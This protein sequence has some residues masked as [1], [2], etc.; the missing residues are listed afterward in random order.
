M[1]S[2]TAGGGEAAAAALGGRRRRGLW[3]GG[4]AQFGS[5]VVLCSSPRPTLLIKDDVQDFGR[6]R[7]EGFS[8]CFKFEGALIEFC[9]NVKV[10]VG[11]VMST[12]ANKWLVI[13]MSVLAAEFQLLTEG[14]VSFLELQA[15]AV[16][17]MKAMFS[18]TGVP[19]RPPNKK[20]EMK[21]DYGLLHDIVAKALCAKA[22]SFDVV[23]SE[24]MELMVDISACLKSLTNRPEKEAVE[25]KR[26]VKEKVV[27]KKKKKETVVVVKKLMVR[28]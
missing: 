15:K 18:G 17:E 4:A 25:N 22:G 5:R 19:F 8:G 21:V 26:L 2:P 14:M 9:A 20:K 12:T 28:K 24:K 13:T 16:A 11:T 23:T 27:E 1:K 7:T 3:R 10:V 6:I